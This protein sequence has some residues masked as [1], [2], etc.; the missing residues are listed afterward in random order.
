M[1]EKNL[2][3]IAILQEQPFN[4]RPLIMCI[5]ATGYQSSINTIITFVGELH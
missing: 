2:S 5:T 4:H 3:K 1:S